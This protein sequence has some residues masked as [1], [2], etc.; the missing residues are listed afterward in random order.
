MKLLKPQAAKAPAKPSAQDRLL[1]HESFHQPTSP[2]PIQPPSR[3]SSA[4]FCPRQRCKGW[5]SCISRSPS[6]AMVSYRSRELSWEAACRQALSCLFHFLLL[7]HPPLH[8]S[9]LQVFLFL[10]LG[11]ATLTATT[12]FAAAAPSK[13]GWGHMAGSRLWFHPH[14]TSAAPLGPPS[15]KPQV[16]EFISDLN[17][18]I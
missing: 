1:G 13:G 7:H 4:A 9:L 6:A 3:L 10:K 12:T 11:E 8:W 2:C 5:L 16:T 17:K 18:L 15:C 14:Q